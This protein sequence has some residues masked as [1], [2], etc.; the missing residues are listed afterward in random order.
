MTAT[1]TRAAV[2]PLHRLTFVEEADG[3]MIG[4]P[5]TGSYALFPAAG[6]DAVRLLG[7]GA[8]PEELASWHVDRYGAPLDVADFTDTLS[9]LGFVRDPDDADDW[10][11]RPVGWQRVGRW[12]FSPPAWA[13]YVS[14]TVVALAMMVRDP[15]LRP[16]YAH[17]F[18]TDHL[19]LIPVCLAAAELPCIMLH[20]GYHALA[21]RRLGLPSTFGIGR[22]FYYLVA[23]TRLDSLYSVPR[24]KRYLPFLAGMIIDVVLVSALTVAAGLGAEHGAPP[25]LTG[26]ALALAFTGAMRVLWQFLFYLETD[27]YFVIAT[28]TRCTDLQ[29]AARYVVRRTV[30]RA[31]HS[32]PAAHRADDPAYLATDDWTERDLRVARFYTPLL[33]LGYAFSL[34]MLFWA[35]IPTTVRF[36]ETLLHRLDGSQPR[37]LG[38]VLDAAFFLFMFTFN[39]GL[40]TYVSVRDRR[41]KK[42][43]RAEEQQS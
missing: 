34:G 16:S 26:F 20:E 19:S 38:A 25:V 36:A 42:A 23:E 5:D 1:P 27:F 15:A 43:Q 41:A 29:N 11:D 35:G 28:A 6:A 13:A 14:V 3:V 39:L 2:S 9:Q 4:R 22:R 37:H 31:L 8:T 30:Y 21:G 32:R 18:F 7:Q 24:A 40:L 12:C 17:L 33:V 10:S